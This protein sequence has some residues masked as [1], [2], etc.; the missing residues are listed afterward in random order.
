MFCE[1][2]LVQF[3][4]GSRFLIFLS[5]YLVLGNCPSTYPVR[6]LDFQSTEKNDKVLHTLFLQPT[7]PLIETN[8]DTKTKLNNPHKHKINNLHSNL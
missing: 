3:G 4:S 6:L 7:S 8:T 5:I 2:G 1:F